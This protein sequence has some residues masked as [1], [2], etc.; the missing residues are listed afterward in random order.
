MALVELYRVTGQERYLDLG[1]YFL[2][3]RGHA[4]LRGG[5]FSPGYRQDDRPF[6]QSLT[7][8]GHCVMAAYLAAGALDLFLETGDQALLDPAV[9][10]WEDMVSRRMYVTGGVGSRHK[11]EAFGDPFELP[12][13]RAYAETCAA[14]GVVLWSW[15]LLLATGE[16]RYADVLERVLYNAFAAGV[17]LD[18]GSYF[19]VNPLQI[20]SGRADPDDGRGAAARR[21]WYQI[22]CC[23][24]NVMRL[25]SSLDRYLVTTTGSGVQI[26]NYAPSRITVTVGGQPAELTV[27]TRFPSDSRVTVRVTRAG[28]LPFEIALRVPG[29]AAGAR[30]RLAFTG[31]TAAA[32]EPAAAGS[33]WRTTRVWRPGDQLIVDLP[34]P[35]RVIEAASQVDAVRGCLAVQQGPLVY[36]MEAADAGPDL[37]AGRLDPSTTFRPGTITMGGTQVPVLDCDGIVQHP[38][39]GPAG[40]LP[41]HD[42]GSRPGQGAPTA[43]RLVP[44]YSWGNREPG[45]A[46]RIWIPAAR[47]NPG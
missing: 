28:Q 23:P 10:Q 16:P 15:R 39:A 22:A 26:W 2:D 27:Q 8:R 38:P 14:I 29:W 45:N 36:C 20:R 25:L 40:A 6:R 19:Y 21:G 24:P 4:L 34:M 18:G 5:E 33:L 1:R 44:Y 12:P 9:A 3:E 41:Y 37:E 7:A 13:D 47:G 30:V 35:A 42:E 17:S 32:W 43:L 31:E 11:D 46:M